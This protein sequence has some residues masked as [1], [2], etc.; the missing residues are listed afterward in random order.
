L[1]QSEKKANE[2]YPTLFCDLTFLALPKLNEMKRCKQECSTSANKITPM[3][4][5]ESSLK[6]TNFLTIASD[7]VF[8]FATRFVNRFEQKQ[9][10]VGEAMLNDNV[11]SISLSI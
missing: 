10:T 7:D 8:S 3:L 2:Q 6:I 4:L 11:R 1:I 5:S 9:L